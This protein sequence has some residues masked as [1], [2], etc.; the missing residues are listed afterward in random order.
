MA[1][2]ACVHTVLTISANNFVSEELKA[3][4]CHPYIRLFFNFFL[5]SSLF[6]FP[7]TVIGV[8][9]SPH[10]HFQA[11]Q[12]I[13]SNGTPIIG[14]YRITSTA[15]SL[16]II[17][18]VR[19]GA[20]YQYVYISINTRVSIPIVY[21]YIYIYIDTCLHNYSYLC[22]FL[23]VYFF[24]YTLLIPVYPCLFAYMYPFLF[25]K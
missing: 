19:M 22:I 18:A 16:N 20:R 24:V 2:H 14:K 9:Q 25:P 5:S 15:G 8:H 7:S 13:V 3:I 11:L 6:Y 21:I 1:V 10:T 12:I 23:H 4:G 17:L